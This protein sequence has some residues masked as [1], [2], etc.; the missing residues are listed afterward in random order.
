M[1]SN[2]IQFAVVR[3]DPASEVA[4]IQ[5]FHA[6]KILLIGSGGCTALTLQSHFPGLEMTIVEPNPAQVTLLQNKIVALKELSETKRKLTF[7][8]ESSDPHGLNACGNF[9]S[10]FRSFRLFIE[11]F[12]CGH[13]QLRQILTNKEASKELMEIFSNKFW[14]VS[15]E[16][17]FSEQLLNCMFGQDATQ[18]APKNSYPKYFQTVLEQG[19]LRADRT[20]N[21]FLQHIFLGYYVDQ[22]NCLP[23]YL[24]LPAPALYRFVVEPKLISEI[25]DFSSYDLI[26]L[27]NIFDWMPEENIADVAQQLI[28]T[29]KKG[30]VIFFRQLNNRKNLMQL[31]APSF[32]FDHDLEESLLAD[33]RS[34][35]YCKFNIGFKI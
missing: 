8:I 2:P 10:L 34:L 15:F 28:A 7:N 24:H 17:F 1:K 33:D 14:A 19:L 13:V 21:Y 3:E 5:K 18:H 12:V 35:F 26:S 25:E 27:S 31:F 16:L 30:C 22:K 9:E 6:K 11:D 4:L 32:S 20:E 23:D 29:S